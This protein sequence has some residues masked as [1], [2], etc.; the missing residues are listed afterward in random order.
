V[1]R[2]LLSSILLFPAVL[3]AASSE[4]PATLRQCRAWA[5]ARS[6]ALKMRREDVLQSRA[7]ARAALSGALPRLDFELT[8]TWQDPEGVEALEQRGFTGFAEKEQRESRFKVSQTLFSGLREFSALSGFKRETARD[9][10]LFERASRDLDEVS[11]ESFYAVLLAETQRDNTARALGLA[12]DRVKDLAGFKRL[13]K[14]RES[15]V[16]SAQAQAAALD[17][18]LQLILARIDSARD[19]LSFLTGVDFNDRPLVDEVPGP[20][21]VSS[22]DEVLSAAKERSDIRAQREEVEARRM[23]V[24]FEKGAAW[25]SLDVTGTYYSQRAAFLEDISW[26]VLASLKMPLFQGGAVA[27]RTAE[28]SSA[29]RQ[30]RLTLE[31][32]ERRV[33]YEV[34]GLHRDLSAAIQES[35]SLEEAAD[36][37]QKSYKALQEEYRLGLVT[38]IE[39]LQS[40]DMALA[41]TSA[42]DASRLRAKLL[43]VRLS[44][45]LDKLP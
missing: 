13:G 38:N 34:R 1:S 31:E 18:Q 40:L 19:D 11:A 33:L 32:L 28:A 22:L 37:A 8:D 27:A 35:R 9:A 45:S 15:E 42:R 17:A 44:L 2:L 10:L 14:A 29:L 7:R 43:F 23:R 36:A 6:E 4:P 16:F 12:R 5:E 20:P 39:V 41:Q 25:P 21:P 24:R 30:A 3:R 26:D